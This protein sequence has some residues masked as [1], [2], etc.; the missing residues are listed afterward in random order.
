MLLSPVSLASHLSRYSCVGLYCTLDLKTEGE[1]LSCD[2]LDKACHAVR[3][4]DWKASSSLAKE[5]EELSWEGLHSGSAWRNV[6]EAIRGAYA[7]SQFILA[8]YEMKSNH[9]LEE[10]MRHLDM[11]LMMGSPPYHDIAN[12]LVSIVQVSKLDVVRIVDGPI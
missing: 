12:K 7:Q 11:A 6:A 1:Y 2:L 3:S 10:A 8:A 5:V 9:N 4:S